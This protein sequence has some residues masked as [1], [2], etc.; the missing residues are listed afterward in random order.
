M[1]I[2]QDPIEGVL[3]LAREIFLD[4]KSYKLDDGSS[5]PY[6]RPFIYQM[7]YMERSHYISFN[8][9]KVHTC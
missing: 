8:E 4:Q 6:H 1:Y 5:T 9:Y 2:R 7:L 3:V